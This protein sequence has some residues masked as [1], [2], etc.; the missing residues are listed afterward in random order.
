M[1]NKIL[2]ILFFLIGCT[3][4]Q[5]SSRIY[6]CGDHPC[7]NKKEI[8]DYFKNNISIEVYTI[9]SNK[10]K[11]EN[12]DLV[13]LNL[14]KKEIN[15][16]NKKSVKSYISKKKHDNKLIKSNKVEKQTKLNLKVQ[17]DD[18]ENKS[19]KKSKKVDQTKS[20]FKSQKNSQTK[21]VHLC[22]NLKECDIDFISKTIMK[23]GKEKSFPEL[24]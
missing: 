2:I 15:N 8:D 21:I 11:R 3:S 19:I 20:V 17:T 22:K 14:L 1:K 4:L 13:D 10:K 7:K 6:I 9:E 23:T 18:S 12:F 24:R 16:K 5:D